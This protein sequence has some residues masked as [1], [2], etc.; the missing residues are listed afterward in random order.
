M[1]KKQAPVLDTHGR[2]LIYIAKY[3]SRLISCVSG[4][5]GS[6]VPRPPPFFVLRFRFSRSSVLYRTKTEEQ[7][8]GEGLGTRLGKRFLLLDFFQAVRQNLGQKAGFE[9]GSLV[10]SYPVC[11]DKGRLCVRQKISVHT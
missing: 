3:M 8:N 9:N 2:M 5:E 6:L 10:A 7:K 4:E 1:E 11:I